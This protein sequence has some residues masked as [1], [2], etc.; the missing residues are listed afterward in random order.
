M[1]RSDIRAFFRALKEGKGFDL[2]NEVKKGLYCGDCNTVDEAG[3]SECSTCGCSA[4]EMKIVEFEETVEGRKIIRAEGERI[5]G[6]QKKIDADGD[7][8][9]SAKDFEILRNKKK[10]K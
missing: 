7:G 9:I 10:N 6:N 5:K 2:I 8:K 1:K 4:N 3:C